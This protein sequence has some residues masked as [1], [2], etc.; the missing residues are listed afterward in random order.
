MEKSVK[1]K[2]LDLL[3]GYQGEYIPQS[4][5]HRA[6]GVSKSWV[7][8]VL[9]T[10]ERDGLITRLNV[11]RSKVIYVKPGISEKQVETTRRH[12]RIGIVYS[13]EYLF[14][15]YFTKILNRSGLYVDVVVYRDGLE[16]TRS[17]AEGYVDIAFSPLVGQVYLQPVYRT[18]R[19]LL[20]GLRGGFKVLGKRDPSVIYS[21]MISTMDYV[22]KTILE[23]NIVN[24]DK[25]IYFREPSII[26]SLVER[27]GYFVVWHPLY[28]ELEKSGFKT[29]ISHRDLDIDFCCTLALSNTITSRLRKVIEKAYVKSL[30]EYSKRPDRFIEYYSL[31]TG[32]DN[33]TLRDAVGEYR[34][35]EGIS[36]KTVENIARSY[37]PGIPSPEVYVEYVEEYQ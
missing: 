6:L 24:V 4:H 20:R 21:S 34:V 23:K 17:L 32:I 22:R 2:I 8:E 28:R 36:K 5:V 12:L 26:H 18:Y 9:Y 31:V 27:G 35:S 37:S 10:L 30:D 15:G 11:G 29:V 25:T 33:S 14:L 16:T 19:I 3:R 7:S 13:S 1:N